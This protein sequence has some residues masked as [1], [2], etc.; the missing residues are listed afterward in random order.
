MLSHRTQ[1]DIF[2]ASNSLEDAEREIRLFQTAMT[3]DLSVKKNT[4]KSTHVG[5]SA[6]Q[7]MGTRTNSVSSKKDAATS[8]ARSAVK[9]TLQ[10]VS[11]F[12]FFFLKRENVDI[13]RQL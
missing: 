5:T 4:R 1:K 2:Y 12:F 9:S 6:V 13:E 7:K 8:T 3:N 11:T 10:P